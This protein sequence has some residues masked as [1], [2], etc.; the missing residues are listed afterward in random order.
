MAQQHP[1]AVR[2]DEMRGLGKWGQRLPAA[3][4]GLDAGFAGVP[5]EAGMGVIGRDELCL[6]FDD[7]DAVQDG[8]GPAV[9]Q[10][11]E[12][13][14]GSVMHDPPVFRRTLPVQIAHDGH[15][16]DEG[17]DAAVAR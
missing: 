7:V 4:Q 1:A 12:L 17:H 8:L 3:E 16:R 2:V 9:D 5:A 14:R 15:Q 11:H 6:G 13:G 10:H